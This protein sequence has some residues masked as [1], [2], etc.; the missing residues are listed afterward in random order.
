MPRARWP[1]VPM[2]RTWLQKSRL[3]AMCLEFPFVA[4]PSRSRHK[5]NMDTCAFR[6]RLHRSLAILQDTRELDE[7]TAIHGHQRSSAFA[8][9]GILR[10]ICSAAASYGGGLR[11]GLDQVGHTE[12]KAKTSRRKTCM[13]TR[14]LNN[15]DMFYKSLYPKDSPRAARN[16]DFKIQI[17]NNWRLAARHL[18]PIIGTSVRAWCDFQSG[19]HFST[20]RSGSARRRRG[21]RLRVSALN[22]G[23]I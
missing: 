11:F 9:T 13:D 18:I 3:A 20:A 1:T 14:L 8:S 21:R 16:S 7:V 12:P 15:W 6:A 22:C 2:A 4:S 23:R 17:P 5:E 10:A 19:Y